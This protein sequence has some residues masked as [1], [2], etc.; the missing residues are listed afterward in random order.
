MTDLRHLSVSTRHLIPDTERARSQHTVVGRPKQVA[1]DA[2][3]VE[4]ESVH[5]EESL[6]VL[7]GLE[8][9]HLTLALSRRLMGHLRSI[10]LVLPRAV[11]HRRHHGTMGRGV[12]PQ[13][14]RDE[15]ARR[16]AL[17]F[18]QLAEEPCSR[19]P[20][21]TARGC[22]SRR[23]PRQRRATDTAAGP[24]GSRRARPDTRCRPSVPVVAAASAH[25][26][27]RRSDTTAGSSR[28]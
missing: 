22:R 25:T 2:E 10:V 19:P 16:P 20:I 13:P 14:V 8:S 17:S 28:E 9:S 12:A 6:R 27:G 15:T 7:G 24:E 23:R 4:H 26:S 21:A 11:Y 1:A 3:E 5:G 18:Q